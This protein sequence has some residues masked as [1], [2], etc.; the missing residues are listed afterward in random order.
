MLK[1]YHEQYINKNAKWKP[2]LTY[3]NRSQTINP[4]IEYL[5]PIGLHYSVLIA[6]FL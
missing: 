4:I 5:R 2:N 1:K 3:L 6:Q